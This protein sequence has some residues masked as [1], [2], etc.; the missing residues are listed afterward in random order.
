MMAFMGLVGRGSVWQYSVVP[1][2]LR[3][4][5]VGRWETVRPPKTPDEDEAFV[6][7]LHVAGNPRGVGGMSP[8][9]YVTS[10]PKPRDAHQC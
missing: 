10:D 1:K 4:F 6:L 5:F 3:V 8:P 2:P 9:I 7:A